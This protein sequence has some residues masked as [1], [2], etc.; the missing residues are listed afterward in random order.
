MI[1]VILKQILGFGCGF[2]ARLNNGNPKRRTSGF[3]PWLYGPICKKRAL[4]TTFAGK[5]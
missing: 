3:C 4:Y 1:K 5:E 2:Q